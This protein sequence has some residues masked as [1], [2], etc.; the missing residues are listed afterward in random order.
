MFYRS[1]ILIVVLS[2]AALGQTFYGSTDLKTFREGRDKE[3]RDRA[4]SPLLEADFERFVGLNYYPVNKAFRL[5]ARF[6]RT[7]DERY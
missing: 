4:Q 7:V 6:T 1:L 3:F 5:K 2:A